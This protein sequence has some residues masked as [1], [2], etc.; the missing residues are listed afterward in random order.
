MA[1]N[2]NFAEAIACYNAGMNGIKYDC[3]SAGISSFMGIT[4]ISFTLELFDRYV[5]DNARYDDR[6]K[7]YGHKL[8]DGIDKNHSYSK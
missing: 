8:S 6:H 5:V 7:G 2:W 4:V 1:S 3:T